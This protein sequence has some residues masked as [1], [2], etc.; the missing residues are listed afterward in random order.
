MEKRKKEINKLIEK[1]KKVTPAEPTEL[2]KAEV[3]AI[4]ADAEEKNKGAAMAYD[5]TRL[6]IMES[7]IKEEI[8][9][10]EHPEHTKDD[11]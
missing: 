10:Y 5:F 11:K 6:Q 4:R 7:H 8:A 2:Q 3:L 1:L 9:V